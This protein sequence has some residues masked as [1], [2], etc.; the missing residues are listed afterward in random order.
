MKPPELVTPAAERAIVVG[1]AFRNE[2]AGAEPPLD[3]LKA[4]AA[5][6]GA[7]VVGE[8]FQK[9]DRPDPATLIGEGKA[10]ELAHLVQQHRAQLVIFDRDL[11]PGQARNL[12]EVV[13]VRVVDRSQLIM[14]I[15]ADRAQT[16]Q[17]KLQVE[18]AQLEY[19]L[20]RLKRMW[21]HLDRY[22]GGIGMRGPGEA[23]IETD[24]RIILRKIGELK[25]EL[26]AIEGRKQREVE[27]RSEYFKVCLVGYTNAGKSSLMNR[28]TGAGAFVADQLF[29]TLDTK[30]RVWQVGP[31]MKV[32]LSDTVGFIRQLPHHLVASFHATLAEA[33]TADLLLHVV[34]G[35][36]V[37]ALEHVRAVDQ[38]LEALGAG[39]VARTLVVNKIDQVQNMGD[40]RVLENSAA[41]TVAVSAHTGAGLD[42]LRLC[43][44]RH[45]LATMPEVELWIGDRENGWLT[46]LERVGT[47]VGEQPDGELGLRLRVALPLWEFASLKRAARPGS[48]LEIVAVRAP[49]SSA[50]GA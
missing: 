43:V 39:K 12:E 7:N 16:H 18:L 36:H 45:L 47:I 29:A 11:S 49:L 15:F 42:V 28:L 25:K 37:A 34:D 35:S 26:D 24:R 30:T 32:L 5:A 1:A 22:K 2:A 3:E 31:K 23:Q 48:G 4:L 27:G 14:D 50:S 33:Q 44:E 21:Q 6:A 41:E 46:H 20:P 10:D 17:A 13:K 9:R 38:V 19:T 8:L 40:V